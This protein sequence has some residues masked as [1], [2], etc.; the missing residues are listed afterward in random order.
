MNR[1]IILYD[2]AT[3]RFDDSKFRRIIR[4]QYITPVYES[5]IKVTCDKQFDNSS[6][7]PIIS[8]LH[9]FSGNHLVNHTTE[10]S[11]DI[12]YLYI[13]SDVTIPL[14]KA[15]EYTFTVLDKNN[16]PLYLAN[17]IIATLTFEEEE[18]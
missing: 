8:A 2:K 14:G 15:R 18:I 6:E 7:Q 11:D 9:C 13:T 4:M 5:V 3:I 16:N 10:H 12:Q 17:P 1:N